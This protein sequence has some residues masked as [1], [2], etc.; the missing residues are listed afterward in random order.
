M[1]SAV[2]QRYP[3]E[4]I[5]LRKASSSSV[6]SSATSTRLDPTAMIVGEHLASG[7]FGTVC[8]VEYRGERDQWVV[9]TE[10]LTE[11]M[12][13]TLVE[14]EIEVLK[15]MQGT[16]GFPQLRAVVREDKRVRL[17][18]QK[19]AWSL[20]DLA[21]IAPLP[22]CDVCRVAV[23]VLDALEALHSKGW[24]HRDIKPQNMMFHESLVYLIDFGLAKRYMELDSSDGIVKHIR[25]T[26]R[27]HVTGTP[28][29]CSIKVHEGNT[30]SRRDDLESLVYTL[31][32]LEDGVLPWMG[33]RGDKAKA[34]DRSKYDKYL[35]KK[36]AVGDSLYKGAT[37]ALYE[38]AVALGFDEKPNYDKL[39]EAF[40]AEIPGTRLNRLN[41]WRFNTEDSSRV[42]RPLLDGVLAIA[43]VAVRG[44]RAN[45]KLR[46]RIMQQLSPQDRL[47]WAQ[48]AHNDPS[49]S[50]SIGAT[51][52]R[53]SCVEE[54]SARAS[55]S[56]GNY[57][58]E[59]N[60]TCFNWANEPGS[61]WQLHMPSV[62]GKPRRRAILDQIVVKCAFTN[63]SHMLWHYETN[64]QNAAF[65][66]EICVT[67][68]RSGTRRFVHYADSKTPA[69]VPWRSILVT[70]TGCLVRRSVNEVVV[71]SFGTVPL[72]TAGAP[73][74]L[75]GVC[76]L[77]RFTVGIPPS[78]ITKPGPLRL[79]PILE[80]WIMATDT[81]GSV[82]HLVIYSINAEGRA[83]AEPGH[84][85]SST[86]EMTSCLQFFYNSA[87][88]TLLPMG[89]IMFPIDFRPN[90]MTHSVKHATTVIW[91]DTRV[92]FNRFVPFATKLTS[93]I[94]AKNSSAPTSSHE[95]LSLLPM[96]QWKRNSIPFKSCR[97]VLCLTISHKV[98]WVLYNDNTIT[99]VD[100]MTF[101]P[102]VSTEED[103]TRVPA[104][105]TFTGPPIVDLTV[106][107]G[108][109]IVAHSPQTRVA[110]SCRQAVSLHSPSIKLSTPS[111]RIVVGT[112]HCLAYSQPFDSSTV[113]TEIMISRMYFN[114]GALKRLAVTTDEVDEPLLRKIPRPSSSS[115]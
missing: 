94:E 13:T 28:R 9:K 23:H 65:R 69:S 81:T 74:F 105:I 50:I 80:P 54:K 22:R 60:V 24:M 43:R 58:L 83:V 85:T 34:N 109:V 49:A 79:T 12:H 51:T 19:L 114:L 18:I 32:Y 68:V 107:R 113:G 90:G 100:A 45:P 101:E 75:D 46:G 53:N 102:F 26:P 1:A 77:S 17:V 87:V 35:V 25:N 8:E 86:V 84:M 115:E 56:N 67:H 88:G 66:T 47:R 104:T 29:Y 96:D 112:L 55:A 42:S 78:D 20:E 38:H 98:Y 72:L 106:D 95:E 44:L 97:E 57:R 16:K 27:K 99:F 31:Q 2:A 21:N 5:D 39:R 15:Q 40:L 14:N 10:A 41:L 76:Q 48:I 37:L 110:E 91:D 62:F 71:A 7:S 93:E 52:H 11:A 4:E 36:R 108:S 70:S 30:Y 111:H 89:V 59:H 33:L 82:S 6:T 103:G 64:P 92:E 73:R 61:P 63:Q 3:V